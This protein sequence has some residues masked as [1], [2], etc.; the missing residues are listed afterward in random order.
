MDMGAAGVDA[1]A[2]EA[3]ARNSII[4]LAVSPRPRAWEVCFPRPTRCPHPQVVGTICTTLPLKEACQDMPLKVACSRRSG[5]LT[6]MSSNASGIGMHATRAASTYPMATPAQHARPNAKRATT[7]TS[8][9]KTGNNILTP[10]GIAA[11]A[12]ATRLS[13]QPCDG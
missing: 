5:P 13:S 1:D 7:F 3:D 9:V 12:T 6:P 10:A 11:L 4:P 8:H 2:A